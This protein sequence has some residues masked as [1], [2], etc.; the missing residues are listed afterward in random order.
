MALPIIL[1][2]VLLVLVGGGYWMYK[3]SLGKDLG[4]GGGYTAPKAAA[5]Y[6]Y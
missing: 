2:V 4:K 6:Y 3:N 1:I 5:V